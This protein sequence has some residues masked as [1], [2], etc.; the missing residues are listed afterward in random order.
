MGIVQATGTAV[1]AQR[2]EGVSRAK[3]LENSMHIAVMRCNELG[4]TDPEIILAAK[5]E[6]RR[7]FLDFERKIAD[8]E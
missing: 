3:R 6:A 2:H 4:I 7:L 8:V 1:S 5:Q